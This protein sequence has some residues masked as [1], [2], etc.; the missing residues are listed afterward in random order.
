MTRPEFNCL[1]TMIGSLPHTDP[2][3]ACALVA[4]YLK[5][6]PTWPQLPKRSFL[7]N[8]IAQ[9]SK[10]LPGVVIRGESI[11]VDHSQEL[12]GPLAEFYTAYLENRIADYALSPEYAAGFYCFLK[13]E[14]LAPLA[15]KGQLTGPVSLGLSLVD[16]SRRAIIYDDTLADATAKLLRLKASWQEEALSKVNKNTIVFLDEPAM[17]SYGSSYVSLSKERVIGL[18]EEVLG[19]LK[20]IKGIHC[21][22]N[23]DWSLIL[24]IGTDIISFDAYNYAASLALYGDDVGSFLAR[25][26]TIAWGIVPSEEKPL[27]DETA[28]SLKDRLE[29]AI[30]PFTRQ[31][32]DFKHLLRRSLITPSCG[33]ALVSPDAAEQALKLTAELSA[34]MRKCYL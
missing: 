11:S 1:P 17:A 7:E 31:G 14:R 26:G 20:G 5:E 8:M 2:E 16:E 21:C 25:G 6:I 13:T 28:S 24:E 27:V 34:K 33:L 4:R 30:V 12:N 32:V 22:G 29:E 3:E 18:L 15:V 9:F 19:G 10:G 23:T